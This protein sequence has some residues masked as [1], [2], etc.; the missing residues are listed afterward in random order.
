MN[1]LI[2]ILD[3]I[4]PFK[5][6]YEELKEKYE[7]QIGACITYEAWNDYLEQSF[8]KDLASWVSALTLAA[9]K[10]GET[11]KE[12]KEKEKEKERIFPDVLPSSS[13]R[14]V[15]DSE[16]IYGIDSNPLSFS[17]TGLSRSL[18]PGCI[19]SFWVNDDGRIVANSIIK[20][21][22][23]FNDTPTER[24]VFNEVHLFKGDPNLTLGF[25]HFAAQN[26]HRFFSKM[27]QHVWEDMASCI[28][29]CINQNRN[30]YS[31]LQNTNIFKTYKEQFRDDYNKVF[32]NNP[33][34]DPTDVTIDHLKDFFIGTK[35][36]LRNHCKNVHNSFLSF[37]QKAKKGEPIDSSNTIWGVD[38][39]WK[40]AKLLSRFAM[41]D[42][43]VN[44]IQNFYESLLVFYRLAKKSLDIK[45]PSEF[46]DD[47]Q[48]EVS[49]NN[50]NSI[51][52]SKFSN[53][54]DIRSYLLNMSKADFLNDKIDELFDGILLSFDSGVEKFNSMYYDYIKNKLRPSYD[55]IRNQLKLKFQESFPEADK[56]ILDV[57]TYEQMNGFVKKIKDKNKEISPVLQPFPGNTE[58]NGY[59]F[60]DIMKA[61]LRLRTVCYYQLGYWIKYVLKCDKVMLSNAAAAA[62][63]SWAS[64]QFG[65]PNLEGSDYFYVVDQSP[66]GYSKNKIKADNNAQRALAFWHNYN[67][68]YAVE[69][70]KKCVRGRNEQ[71]WNIWFSKVFTKWEKKDE[72]QK[73]PNYNI[74]EKELTD[75]KN[76]TTGSLEKNTMS[77]ELPEITEFLKQ[78]GI[79]LSK[80]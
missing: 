8:G 6:W 25:G 60:Y 80:I 9:N 4:L 52:R 50:T 39:F 5:K 77:E 28:L 43:Y 64:S 61:S 1:E 55:A 30:I 62:R 68:L 49:D 24:R 53:L 16:I 13:D 58:F 37:I 45:N 3:L 72:K 11:E 79:D 2:K 71:I 19:P 14:F 38:C 59:W 74:T 54:S 23:A 32:Q 33:I 67:V 41:K 22:C 48:I 18:S 20:L 40:R 73:Y 76:N 29:D 7:E 35:D 46:F 78:K 27:P 26:I 75:L 36:Q 51:I 47:S 34:G 21:I 31:G 57:Y 42:T 56:N 10:E 65:D 63:S 15:Q 69:Q 12:E 17:K 66:K 44:K 70:G